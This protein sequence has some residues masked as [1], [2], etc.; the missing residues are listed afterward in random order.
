MNE[1]A[2]FYLIVAVVFFHH[3]KSEVDE[4]SLK[5]VISFKKNFRKNTLFD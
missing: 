1:K 3:S 5:I 4:T 2:Y